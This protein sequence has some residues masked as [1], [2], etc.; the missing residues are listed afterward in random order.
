MQRRTDSTA[1]GR[2]TLESS[3]RQ[4]RSA[5]EGSVKPSTVTRG[6]ET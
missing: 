1:D 3:P 4:N 6:L 2:L 5:E